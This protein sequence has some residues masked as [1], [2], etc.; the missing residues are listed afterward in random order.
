MPL[1]TRSWNVIHGMLS[2][3]VSLFERRNPE[4]LLEREQERFRAFVGDFNQGLV[5]HATLSERLTSK[6]AA[7]E[8]RLRAGTT[9]L[10]ACL[11]AGDNKRAGQQALALKQVE[12]GLAESKR[13]LAQS[14]ARYQQLVEARDRAV[15]EARARIE[16]L[17]FQIGDL[18]VNRAMADLETMASEMMGRFDDP[19]DGMNRLAE[20]VTEENDKARAR[21]RVAGGVS[22]DGDAASRAME[23]ELL[24]AQ[25]LQE[26]EARSA[27]PEPLALPDYSAPSPSPVPKKTAH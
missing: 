6:I 25:A 24:E 12:E 17:R 22:V 11:S 26:F 16:H 5:T 21:S 20:L 19:G 1:L 14:E 13:K 2:R 9:R 27:A 23:R 3:L 18:K 4:A 10:H 8:V 15:A 7:D